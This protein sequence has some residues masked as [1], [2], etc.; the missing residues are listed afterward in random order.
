MSPRS[1]TVGNTQQFSA[2]AVT[3]VLK[4]LNVGTKRGA[5]ERWLQAV[6]ARVTNQRSGLAAELCSLLGVS[7]AG[8]GAG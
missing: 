1:T 4:H 3:K 7:P 5:R 6:A 8:V 2:S